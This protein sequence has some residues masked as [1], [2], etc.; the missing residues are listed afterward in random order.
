MRKKEQE[1][2]I[3]PVTVERVLDT[4]RSP[5]MVFI[6]SPYRPVAINSDDV[7]EHCGAG[8]TDAM[9]TARADGVAD[10]EIEYNLDRARKA[11]ALAVLCNE[12]PVAPHLM[13][14]QFMDDTDPVDRQKAMRFSLRLLNMSDEVWFVGR[15]MSE[16]MKR[17][18]EV[19]KKAGIP[20]YFMD[21]PDVVIRQLLHEMKELEE[22]EN[23]G[24]DEG[25]D[26]PC[27]TCP[28]RDTCPALHAEE[29]N[30]QENEEHDDIEALYEKHDAEV[31]KKILE[32]IDP[33]Q[34]LRA[35]FDDS[36]D[37]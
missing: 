7:D 5:K 27:A 32:S 34:L 3:C 15:R 12:M 18:L 28:D 30:A 29:D 31:M 14:P 17:E 25:I 19:A 8:E 33:E 37:D 13:Y 20:Y 2:Y 9:E 35:I 21:E 10:A 36:E 22:D 1:T 24:D 23:G 26:D 16:G 4:D 11:C 6:S